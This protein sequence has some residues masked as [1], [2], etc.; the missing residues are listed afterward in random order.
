MKSCSSSLII[1]EMQIKTTVRY[2]LTPVRMAIIKKS[3]KN[4]CWRECGVKGT[5]LHCWW[6]YKLIQSLWRTVW[7]FLRKLKIELPFDPTI[8]LLGIYLEKT[9]I[10]KV[11]C[12]ASLV[13]QWLRIC[14]LM[15]GTWVWALVWEDPTCRRATRPVHHNYW[16]CASGACAPQRKATI[17]R[18]AHRDEEWPPLAAARGSPCTET[19]TQHS[20]K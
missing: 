11:T 1:R 14:L 3:T 8:P 10:Q 7:S 9:I 2:H 6:E 15:Q 16:A 5:L 20:Q 13:A 12:W 4:K 19:K 17:V 18:P